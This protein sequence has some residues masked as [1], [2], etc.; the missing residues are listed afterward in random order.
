[1]IVRGAGYTKAGV[2]L[3]P[4]DETVGANSNCGSIFCVRWS[5]R[6][7]LTALTSVGLKARYAGQSGNL[8]TNNV[9]LDMAL[10]LQD[11]VA[12]VQVKGWRIEES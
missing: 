6:V 2:P 1:V 9:N 12:L 11:P 5:E 4:F 10:V 3:L 7:D 8:I